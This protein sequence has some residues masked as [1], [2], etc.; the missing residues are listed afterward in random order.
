[1]HYKPSICKRFLSA[2]ATEMIET[3]ER[4][5]NMRFSISLTRV[6]IFGNRYLFHSL[7]NYSPLEQFSSECRKQFAFVLLSLLRSVIG[8]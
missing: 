7:L 1:M 2:H 4:T 8:F 6:V 3:I 5:K